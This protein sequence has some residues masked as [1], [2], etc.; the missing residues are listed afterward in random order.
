[1]GRKGR[2]LINSGTISWKEFLND[3]I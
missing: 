1:V 3:K 2:H